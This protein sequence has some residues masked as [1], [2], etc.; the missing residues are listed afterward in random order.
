MGQLSYKGEGKVF[1]V[2]LS[3]VTGF[4]SDRCSRIFSRFFGSLKHP[5][6]VNIPKKKIRSDEVH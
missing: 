4:I 1:G 5:K 2:A 6:R 3:C